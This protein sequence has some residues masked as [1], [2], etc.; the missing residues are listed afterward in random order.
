MARATHAPW[1]NTIRM[2]LVVWIVPRANTVRL[3]LVRAHRALTLRQYHQSI[4]VRVRRAVDL[5]RPIVRSPL[6]Q[7]VIT[8]T[9]M[10]CAHRALTFRQ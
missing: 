2:A 10:A 4:P 8:V 9:P 7:Q 3:A 6:V 5:M 1:A